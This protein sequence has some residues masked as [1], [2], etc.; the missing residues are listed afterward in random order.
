MAYNFEL[1]EPFAQGAARILR[2]QLDRARLHLSNPADRVSAVH[3]ARKCFKRARSL[4]RLMRAGLSKTEFG[5]TNRAIRDVARSLAQSRDLDVMVQTL[6][7]LQ[8]GHGASSPALVKRVARAIANARAAASKLTPDPPIAT[9]L[10]QLAGI[11]AD[12]AERSFERCTRPALIAGLGRELQNLERCYGEAVALTTDTAFHEWRKRVQIHRRHVELVAKVWP[13][14][15]EPRVA[16]CRELSSLLGL[17]HDLAVLANFV[18]SDQA[19]P[20]T[21]RDAGRISDYCNAEQA[22]LRRR[23]IALG[24]LLL[25]E[26][27]TAFVA[28][29][30]AYWQVRNAHAGALPAAAE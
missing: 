27:P 12:L 17:D 8:A 2:E 13:Q 14:M 21:K 5:K 1:S 28:R 16:V 20:A 29:V 6:A 18:S 11:R 9:A 25:A 7:H 23:S 22:E 3:E 26:P 15:L 19:K 10:K 24:A 30:D 4:L